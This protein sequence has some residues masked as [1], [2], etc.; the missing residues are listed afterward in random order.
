MKFSF[1]QIT[2]KCF[3]SRPEIYEPIKRGLPGMAGTTHSQSDIRSHNFSANERLT[4]VICY[5]TKL[6]YLK[7]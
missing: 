3:T 4:R 1:V 2:P 5:S 7:D 6:W